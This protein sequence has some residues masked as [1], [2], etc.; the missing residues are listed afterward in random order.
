MTYD[1][2]LKVGTNTRMNFEQIIWKE[3]IF[4]LTLCYIMLNAF[5]LSFIYITLWS[6]MTYVLI[7]YISKHML[8]IMFIR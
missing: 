8:E 1:T 7:I 2:R 5:T 3:Q 4:S 6:F